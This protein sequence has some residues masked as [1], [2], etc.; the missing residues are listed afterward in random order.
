[1]KMENASIDQLQTIEA[2]DFGELVSENSRRFLPPSAV[3]NV[4]NESAHAQEVITF[5]TSEYL[6]GL[7]AHTLQLSDIWS[8]DGTHGWETVLADGVYLSSWQRRVQSNLCC[9]LWTGMKTYS[10]ST[11]DFLTEPYFNISHNGETFILK[12]WGEF[13]GNWPK[14]KYLGIDFSADAITSDLDKTLEGVGS[15]WSSFA[16][17]GN[18]GCNPSNHVGE[19]D[20]W[21]NV[22]I[23]FASH[24]ELVGNEFSE[25]L[26]GSL[27]K[28]A[29][30]FAILLPY[31]VSVNN[32]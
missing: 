31:R 20:I 23:P 21:W 9:E 17:K 8:K 18:C 11:G 26:R 32:K 15:A 14:E 4:K 1:M 27:V 10:D 29:G 28:L 13:W 6:K 2:E 24:E 22:A 16:V 30:N 19:G 5:N 3:A 25:K 7:R 12:V